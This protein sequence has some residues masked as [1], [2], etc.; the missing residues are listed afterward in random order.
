[1]KTKANKQELL[2]IEVLLISSYFY[3]S[4]YVLDNK[5]QLSVN[6]LIGSITSKIVLCVE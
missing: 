3:L 6:I 4:L 2:Y 5:F 1:M